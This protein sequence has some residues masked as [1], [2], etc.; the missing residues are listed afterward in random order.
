MCILTGDGLKDPQVVLKA[1]IK[2][3]T[4]YPQTKEFF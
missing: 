4:I 1:A 2:P 3:P